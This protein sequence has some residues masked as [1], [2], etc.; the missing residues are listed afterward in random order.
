MTA[1]ITD[2]TLPSG[3]EVSGKAIT[4]SIAFNGTTQLYR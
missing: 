1:T 2:L 4:G 3:V